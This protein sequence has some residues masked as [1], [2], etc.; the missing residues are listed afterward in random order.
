MAA[1]PRDEESHDAT[2]RP[3]SPDARPACA[4][5]RVAHDADFT[6]DFVNVGVCVMGSV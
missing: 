2:Q 1:A 5:R 6:E 3:E 4:P